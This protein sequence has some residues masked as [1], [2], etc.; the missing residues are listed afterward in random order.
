VQMSVQVPIPAGERWIFTLRMPP[1]SDAVAFSVTVPVS[2]VPGSVRE[3]VGA[4][5]SIRRFETVELVE[6]LPATSLPKARKS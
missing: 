4:T 2:G 1:P 6:L 3:T 5:L